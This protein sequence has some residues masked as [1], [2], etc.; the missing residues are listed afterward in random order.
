[1]LAQVAH[2]MK[3]RY[4]AAVARDPGERSSVDWSAVAADV[5]AGVSSDW[6]LD[7]DPHRGWYD[8]VLDY[9]TYPGWQEIPYWIYGMADQSG[10]YQKW[11][12]VP[13]DSMR[14]ILSDSTDVVIVTP[15]LRFPRGTTVTAQ[16]DSPGTYY[17]NP[18]P[19]SEGWSITSLWAQ[20]DRQTWRWSY[21]WASRF[22]QYAYWNDFTHNEI[23]DTEMQLLK[24]EALYRTGDL[25][26]AAALINVSRTASGL[27]ATDAAG[28]NTDCVPKLPDGTCGGLFEMLK[29]EKRMEVMQQGLFGA[30]WFFDAR[31]WGDLYEGT[32]LQLPVPCGVLLKAGQ[33]CYTFGGANPSSAP[34]SSY[35]WPGEG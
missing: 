27:S 5:D 9:G 11:L 6:A 12:A 7:M 4:R 8:E 14:P 28:T 30:P 33:S 17:E 18:N 19:D 15:D 26:G 1:M 22:Q 2:S 35:G 29:W 3:A 13:V 20:A 31:G 34:K 21:Y 10:N 25:A 16:I 24:A 23:D 32:Y